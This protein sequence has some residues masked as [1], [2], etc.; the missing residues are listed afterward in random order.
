VSKVNSQI[1]KQNFDCS[2]FQ[3]F[4]FQDENRMKQKIRIHLLE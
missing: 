3:I 1:D 4:L 2:L